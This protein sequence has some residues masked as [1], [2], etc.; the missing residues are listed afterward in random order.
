MSG[1]LLIPVHLDRLAWLFIYSCQ[2]LPDPG[3][4]FPDQGMSDDWI[5]D[6]RMLLSASQQTDVFAAL[7]RQDRIVYR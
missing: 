3:E 7:I 4:G 6:R 5:Y 2:R 1:A